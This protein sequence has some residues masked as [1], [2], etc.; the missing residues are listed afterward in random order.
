MKTHTLIE[1]TEQHICITVVEY[2]M[3]FSYWYLTRM[4]IDLYHCLLI[5]VQKVRDYHAYNKY[6]KES[7]VCYFLRQLC[8]RSISRFLN[9]LGTQHF[10]HYHVYY[11]LSLDLRSWVCLSPTLVIHAHNKGRFSYAVKW[12]DMCMWL[13]WWFF[14]TVASCWNFFKVILCF[15]FLKYWYI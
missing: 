1:W 11:V 4:I 14:D 15:Y 12:R 9:N 10:S 2:I 8:W 6:E 5:K 13:S 7:V 3:W